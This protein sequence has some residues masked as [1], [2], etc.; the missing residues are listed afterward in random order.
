MRV[1]FVSRMTLLIGAAFLA[2]ASQAWS[3][4]TLQWI[5]VAGGAL[6]IVVALADMVRDNVEQRAIDALVVLLG[7]WTVVEAFA[8]GGNNLQWWS[9][10]SAAALAGLATLGLIAHETSTE[11]VVH[12][13]SVTHEPT[14]ATSRV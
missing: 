3:G 8:F 7:A 6:M 5:F 12:E 1:H 4:D 9:F 11:R 14:R 10:A 2:F 13:L